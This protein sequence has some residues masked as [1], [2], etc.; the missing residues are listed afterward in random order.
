MRS[1][2]GHRVCG[3]FFWEITF[4]NMLVYRWVLVFCVVVCGLDVLVSK[5]GCCW[6]VYIIKG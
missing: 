2:F 5:V 3:G 1:S 6:G 4:V